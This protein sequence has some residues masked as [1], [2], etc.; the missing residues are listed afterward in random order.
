MLYNCLI[1]FSRSSLTNPIFWLGWIH[2]PWEKKIPTSWQIMYSK[3]IYIFLKQDITTMSIKPNS[4]SKQNW[5]KIPHYKLTFRIHKQW[6]LNPI[7]NQIVS[8]AKEQSQK[9][10]LEAHLFKVH[11]FWV[12]SCYCWEIGKSAF[13]NFPWNQLVKTILHNTKNTRPWIRTCLFLVLCLAHYVTLG[14]TSSPLWTPVT[15]SIM[16]GF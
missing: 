8:S 1:Q 9:R 15:S 3:P 4:S 14:K 10:Y 5:G 16:W 12:Y 13:P 11:I 6:S 2:C 7:R